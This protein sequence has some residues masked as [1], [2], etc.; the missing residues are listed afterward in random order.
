MEALFDAAAA[1]VVAALWR[2]RREPRAV[3]RVHPTVWLRVAAA[4][5]AAW[6]ALVVVGMVLAGRLTFA[7]ATDDLFFVIGMILLPIVLAAFAIGLAVVGWCIGLIRKLVARDASARIDLVAV[8]AWG[9]AT[10]C[11]LSW[12][13]HT[14]AIAVIVA[15]PALACGVVAAAPEAWRVDSSV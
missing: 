2:A 13:A 9:L 10:A 11:W 12:V 7:L 3:E 4:S 15:T 1:L 6:A 5:V 14:V 8:A